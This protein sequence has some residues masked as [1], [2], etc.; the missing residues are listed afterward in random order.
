MQFEVYI[1]DLVTKL[2]FSGVGLILLSIMVAVICSNHVN[3]YVVVCRISPAPSTDS[4]DAIVCLG[5]A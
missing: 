1:L 5:K 2:A 3:R 4:C